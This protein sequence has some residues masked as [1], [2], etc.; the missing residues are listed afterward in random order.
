MGFG[1]ARSWL[2]LA[3]AVFSSL[4]KPLHINWLDM[5]DN[6]KGQ[7]QYFTEADMTTWKALGMSSPQWN[8]EEAIKDYVRN[9]LMANRNL[10]QAE[11]QHKI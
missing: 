10:A 11:V 1:T 7:Y 3:S 4:N 2:D 5:P 8:L 9:Y 6:I